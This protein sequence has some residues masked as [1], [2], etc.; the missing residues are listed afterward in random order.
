MP[1]HDSHPICYD[2][3]NQS[4]LI[5]ILKFQHYYPLKSLEFLWNVSW[6]W[7]LPIALSMKS[8]L[9]LPLCKS[10]PPF[11]IY[12]L[13]SATKI[14]RPH[15]WASILFEKKWRQ[16]S[17]GYLKRNKSAC[18]IRVI[19]S[20]RIIMFVIIL[21]IFLILSFSSINVRWG[22]WE[23]LDAGMPFRLIK[24]IYGVFLLLT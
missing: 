3:W 4:C 12:K 5:L 11:S 8:V 7:D 17:F 15:V 18:A 24:L 21:S 22:Y 13:A 6:E 16:N 14:K 19:R 2:L 23:S 10:F 20:Q 9:A 1:A